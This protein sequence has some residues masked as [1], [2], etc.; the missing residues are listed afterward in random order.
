LHVTPFAAHPV[1][2]HGFI[3][4]ADRSG[5]G[6]TSLAIGLMRA[7]ARA[8]L[9]VRGA[10][11]GPDYIDPGFHRAAT[12]HEGVNLDSWA[13]EP[14]LLDRLAGRQAS[15]AGLVII[16]SAMGLFDGVEGVEGRTGAAADLAR[17][18][19]LPVL[20][21]HDVSGH[22][23]TAAAILRGM[24]SHDSGVRIGGVVLN[25]AG[26]DRH[27]RLARAAIERIGVPVLGALRRDAAMA[28]PARHLGLVQAGEHD[29]LDAAIDRLAD[30]V[31]QALD[32]DAVKAMAAPLQAL[33]GSEAAL[34]PPPGQRI[35]LARD[36]AFSFAY[37]HML[38]HWRDSG[39]EIVPFSPLA[40]EGPD[41]SCDVAWL[42]G[43]YPELHAGRLAAATRFRDSLAAFASGR[44]VHGEGGGFIALG[45]TLEDGDG[46]VHPMAGLLG[47]AT[48]F[49]ARRLSLGYRR[50]VLAA[51]CPL[52]GAGAMINGHEFHYS[53]LIESGGDAPLAD[54]SDGEG[55][56][57][58][59]AGARRGNVT[60]AFFHAIAQG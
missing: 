28:L 29:A 6:K 18:F 49:A 14:A 46:V 1:S 30:A 41:P 48:S 59:P 55:R 8:G 52:G 5:A 26:S 42:P 31:E 21:V 44:P 57:L 27:E 33:A 23:Q 47:H 22:S 11:S 32:L 37:P 20:L 19:Q 12:G 39:A 7:F 60:G 36:A 15:G 9:V 45:R 16:E 13:M 50:A 58:G 51:D 17:R 10:K 3:V 53:S 25:K 2:S 56:S 38:A 34:L 43:G 54:L 24:A 40:D 4:G 35:A